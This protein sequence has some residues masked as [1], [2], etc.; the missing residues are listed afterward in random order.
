[1]DRCVYIYIYVNVNILYIYIKS[2]YLL[3]L[4]LYFESFDNHIINLNAFPKS[5]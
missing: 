4:N 3:N 1:M 2:S 5:M